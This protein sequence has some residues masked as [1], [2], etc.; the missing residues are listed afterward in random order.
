MQPK[1]TYASL[2]VE[3]KKIA[4]ESLGLGVLKSLFSYS[5]T[6]HLMIKIS[7]GAFIGFALYHFQNTRMKNGDKY[8]TGVIDAICVSTPYR[9]E[10]FGTLLTFGTL[11]KMSAYGAD[12]VELMLKTPGVDDKDGYPGVPLIG[13]E[14]LL[15]CLGFRKVQVFDKHYEKK[16]LQYGYDCLFCGNRPDSCKGMLYA[17][18]DN[19]ISS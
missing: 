5:H 15:F 7:D 3:I 17:I 18:N 19:E 8:V 6:Y 2:P 4:N 9:N 11:R 13:N 1:L 12:R 16:S 14:E 10:G